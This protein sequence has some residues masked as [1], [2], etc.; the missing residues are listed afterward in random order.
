MTMKEILGLSFD[1]DISKWRG[2]KSDI[3]SMPSG[4]KWLVGSLNAQRWT[5]CALHNLKT[6]PNFFKKNS[7]KDSTQIVQ[8]STLPH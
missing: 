1:S 7:T 3:Y 5:K 6:T 8:N 2:A 4:Y